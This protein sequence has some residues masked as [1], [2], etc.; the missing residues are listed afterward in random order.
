[1][2]RIWPIETAISSGEPV[3]RGGGFEETATI[4]IATKAEDGVI[5]RRAGEGI[6]SVVAPDRCHDQPRFSI[7]GRFALAAERSA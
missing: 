4:P 6:I 1:M 3:F 7:P 2:R 5:V